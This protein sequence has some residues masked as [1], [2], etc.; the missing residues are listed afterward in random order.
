MTVQKYIFVASLD[1]LKFDAPLGSGWNVAADLKISTSDTIAQRLLNRFMRRMIGEVEANV[2]LRGNPFLFSEGDYPLE[3]TTPEAQ[4]LLL[5]SRLRIAVAF[6]NVLWLTKDNSVNF[7]RGF[8]QYPHARSAPASRVSVNSWTTRYSKADGQMGITEFSK[9]ELQSAITMYKLLFGE[10]P[11]DDVSPPSTPGT[12]G[13]VGR[14]DHAFYFLQGARAMADLPHKVTNYCTSFEALV[15]TSSTELAHQ[16]SERVAVLISKD[17]A[18]AKEIYRNLKRAYDTRSKLVHGGQLTATNDRYLTES[19]NCD[20]YLRRALK[21]VLFEED[22]R[23]ALAQDSE[24]V[25]EFFFD[26]L[27]RGVNL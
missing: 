20:Q 23:M 11:V 14:V 27:F 22:V 15:S 18:E 6:C 2:I 16:V 7:D 9:S 3:D 26:R 1:S 19:Q 25:N 13:S 5:N 21:T 4:E 17:S 24:K 12:A 10:P 8:L